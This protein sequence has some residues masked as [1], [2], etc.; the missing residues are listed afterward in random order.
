L[1]EGVITII[2]SIIYAFLPVLTL[3]MNSRQPKSKIITNDIS[4]QSAAVCLWYMT[5][6]GILSISYLILYLISFALT[7]KLIY[8]P[9]GNSL[10][11]IIRTGISLTIALPPPTK[12]ISK[13]IG[14]ISCDITNNP[15]DSFKVLKIDQEE[16]E[17]N[18]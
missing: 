11:S 15:G 14:R 3:H 6:T 9:I 13:I 2:S 5:I 17:G 18:V 1:V 16:F 10:D 8:N 12:L 7:N 4:A